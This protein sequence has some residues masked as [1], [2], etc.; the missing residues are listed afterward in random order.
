MK[1]SLT[2][3]VLGGLGPA[4]TLDFFGKVL[5][6]TGARTDQEH[7]HVVV[8][9]NPHVPNRNEAIA[10]RGPSPGPAL[11]AGAA[12]L[13]RAG[14]DFV[15][16]VCN[17]AHAWQADIEAALSVP[18]VSLI[19]ETVAE[20]Q[21]TPSICRVGVL[22]TSGCVGAKLYQRAFHVAGIEAIVLG[23]ED[24]ERFMACI[25]AVKSGDTGSHQ[26]AEMKALA[27]LLRARGADAI[28]AACTEVPL[29]LSE[30]DVDG[31][32]I[33]STDVLVHRTVERA[34]HGAL[35]P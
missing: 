20:V 7:L 3:G 23:S 17:T 33:S 18:F 5:K 30:A 12:A 22:A 2:V 6:A 14:A 24:M 10:G 31:P 26:R 16:M 8:N 13:E 15:V 9:C 29:V 27:T 4:A 25:Y 34:R 21:K 28:I 35:T 1:P 11:G 32:L 19:D